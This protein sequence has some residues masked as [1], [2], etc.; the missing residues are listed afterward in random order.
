MFSHQPRLT[1]AI[2]AYL[3][4]LTIANRS[5][6]TLHTYRCILGRFTKAVGDRPPGK[7]VIGDFHHYFAGL[8]TFS[9]AYRSLVGHVI[10]GFF[11][12][13]AEQGFIKTCPIAN[14]RLPQPKAD[15]V[16]PFRKDE[17]KALLS[18]ANTFE[19]A[20]V[21]LLLDTGLRGAEL[22]ALRQPDVDME[23]GLLWI[24]HGK[25]DKPRVVALNSGPKKALR[26]YLAQN[27]SAN[28]A[29]WPKGFDRPA[30]G[31]LLDRLARRARVS[32]VHP[33]RFRHTFACYFY[34]QT[35]DALALQQICGWSSL[36]MVQ[37]YT[38]WVQEQRAL[39]V[40]KKHSLVA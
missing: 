15:P 10:K 34:L 28:G 13:C 14:L 27:Q 38:A 1:Q 3:S 33:H 36:A 9:P 22:A 39:G 29:I 17:I 23:K 20:I 35:N 4:G 31:R 30:L 6:E 21:K 5:E 2:E 40:H 26:S 19:E 11:H 7:I 12:W 37:R 32:C 25:G 8:A 18:K 24:R 16:R